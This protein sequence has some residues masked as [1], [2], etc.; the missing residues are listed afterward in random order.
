MEEASNPQRLS[1]LP[2]WRHATQ[3][4]LLTVV[5]L[6]ELLRVSKTKINGSLAAAS[7][8]NDEERLNSLRQSNVNQIHIYPKYFVIDTTRH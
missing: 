6:A 2:V 8:P 5:Y 1:S 7:Q 3:Q 4:K